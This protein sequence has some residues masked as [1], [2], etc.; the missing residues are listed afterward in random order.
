VCHVITRPHITLTKDCFKTGSPGVRTINAGETYVETFTVTNDGDVAVQNVVIHDT[1]NGVTTDY[2][3][4]AGPLAPGAS[5]T[6]TTPPISTTVADCPS[7]TDRAVATAD[8]VCPPDAVCP[9][10]A[11]VSSA[12]ATCTINVVCR[13]E[14]TINKE[15]AC[16]LGQNN[17]G[18]FGDVATGVR[19]DSCPAFCYRFTIT[20]PSTTVPLVLTSVRD[21][22]SD[23]TS[24]DLTSQFNAGGP[25]A[26]GGS[27]TISVAPRTHCA[28]TT[29]VVTAICT[30]ADGTRHEVRDT[31][32]AIV[33]KIDLD[34]VD[35]L[36]H[37]SIDTDGISQGEIN[38]DGTVDPADNNHV[39]LPANT[40]NAPITLTLTL[41][42]IG[43]ATITV[44]QLIGLPAGLYDCATGTP[45]DPST[46]VGFDLAAG[47]SRTIV[48]GCVDVSCP[49]ASFSIS[50]HGVASDQGGTLCVFNAQ[51]VRVGD[52]SDA[53]PASVDCAPP[54]VEAACRVTGGGVLL[55]G[56]VDHSCID[57]PT[58]I[59]PS[60]VNHL[61]VKKITHGGQLG[62]PFAHM[63][64][65]AILGNICIRGNWSH[66]RHYEGTGNP[67]DVV[68]MSFHSETPKGR[69][70]SLFCA[71]LG[72]CDPE[73]GAFIPASS[74]G[75]FKKFQICNPDDHK[76]CGPQPRPSPAN[77]I[78]WSGVGRIR[79]ETDGGSN[80]KATEYVIFRVY[81][82]DRSEPGGNHPG[83]AVEPADIYCFQAWKTG[84]KEVKR[85]DFSQVWLDF[86]RALGEANCAFLE[87]LSA[88]AQPIGSLPSPT[89]NG[90]T[91]DIQDC[92]PM[93]S[94]NHQIHPVTGA[95]AKCV[96]A[97][98]TP[99]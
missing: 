41:R 46:L 43:T 72:C 66:T 65:G 6:F 47:A 98:Q 31:N 33:L 19:D 93:Y 55:P 45:V 60:V 73:T 13:C 77:A 90:V 69:Y 92:G 58:T 26:P 21:V 2:V 16:Y 18:T 7:I 8:Q 99:P 48:L 10:P 54:E 63:D 36:L 61:T 32:I 78:I 67:R 42:N 85:P 75:K 80:Q 40:Q 3:C 38:S 50:A 64:C 62:A 24:A 56:N 71:C 28:N 70:D 49:G 94:G 81:I 5:C 97:S 17:C 68:D 27:R 79:P 37:S 20:N 12:Q 39:T 52:T 86:R 82:E 14:L 23:G 22:S 44:D 96:D 11:T 53:C 74:G 76:I 84:I 1:K 25:I 34:C 59:F 88:G 35:L 91:A 89:V 83:G 95:D 57:V 29:N 30:D 9:S 4:S 51:G 87:G 15:V